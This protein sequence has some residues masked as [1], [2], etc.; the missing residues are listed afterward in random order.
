M[1]SVCK[2]YPSPTKFLGQSEAQHH[3]NLGNGCTIST[4]NGTNWEAIAYA[5]CPRVAATTLQIVLSVLALIALFL[6]YWLLRYRTVL[7][8]D[9][10]FVQYVPRG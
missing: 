4:W 9:D 3:T 5:Y 1:T 10:V 8:L 6:L 7:D 2:R